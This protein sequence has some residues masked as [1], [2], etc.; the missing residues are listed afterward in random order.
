MEALDTLKLLLGIEGSEQD[1]KLQ[2]TLDNAREIVLNYCNI[3]EIPEGL[4]NTVVRMA[5]D[6]YRNE[7]PGES[8]VPQ[9]LKSVTT[10]DTSTS[11]S[12]TE[13]N[14]YA[15]SLLRNYKSQLNRYRRVVF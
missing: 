14:G 7:H 8:D 13:T 9:A 6:I 12:I 10:G 15:Q 11:F 3:D 1:A 4:N 2:F 5:V